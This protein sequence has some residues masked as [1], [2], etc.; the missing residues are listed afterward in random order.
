MDAAIRDEAFAPM[1]SLF[2]IAG[3]V[4]RRVEFNLIGITRRIFQEHSSNMSKRGQTL[5]SL[6]SDDAQILIVIAVN[7]GTKRPRVSGANLRKTFCFCLGS[8]A[9]T[10]F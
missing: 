10:G 4:L 1:G 2:L 6:E 8:T 7:A 5:L 3:A 9:T